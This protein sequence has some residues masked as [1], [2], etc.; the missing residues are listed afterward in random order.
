MSDD[1]IIKRRTGYVVPP[2]QKQEPKVLA[3]AQSIET[4]NNGWLWYVLAGIVGLLVI[5]V[6]WGWSPTGQLGTEHTSMGPQEVP[7]EYSEVLE[8]LKAAAIMASNS[9]KN[10]REAVRTR[11]AAKAVGKPDLIE[12]MKE[13]EVASQADLRATQERYAEVLYEVHTLRQR[14]TNEFDAAMVTVVAQMEAKQLKTQVAE[15]SRAVERIKEIP[16]NADMAIFVKIVEG[17]F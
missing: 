17:V 7:K 3:A 11:E 14:K 8:R 16:E 2:Q 5:A 15:L 6:V 10:Y 4:Q 1:P 12:A 13:I 9:S